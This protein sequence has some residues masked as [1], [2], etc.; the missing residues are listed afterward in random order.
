M[1]LNNV[2]SFDIMIKIFTIK[3]VMYLSN[4]SYHRWKYYEALIQSLM[5]MNCM[6]QYKRI[7]NEMQ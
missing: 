1:R 6:M 4:I 2:K 5:N 7:D 3:K